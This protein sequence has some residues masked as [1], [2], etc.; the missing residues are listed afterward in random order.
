VCKDC[1]QPYEPD[2]DELLK[3]RIKREEIKGHTCHKGRGC[4]TC[5]GSGY[6]GRVALY[7]IM[8]MTPKVEQAIYDRKDLNDL[9]DVCIS[10]GMQT[11]RML[12]VK[13]WKMGVTSSDEVVAVT[14]AA[15]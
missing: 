4:D 6:K 7:E 12:A 3:L 11:L 15:D 8:C 1:K 14:A 5:G 9:T 10:E 13:K 2:D